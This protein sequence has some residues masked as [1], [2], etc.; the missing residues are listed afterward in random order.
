MTSTG[1][2]Q[3]CSASE[4]LRRVV[5]AAAPGSEPAEV[6]FRH[7]LAWRTRGTARSPKTTCLG[8]F[9]S[10]KEPA[11][12]ERW[13][14]SDVDFDS[15]VRRDFL[16][17]VT[18][19]V[20]RGRRRRPR[21]DRSDRGTHSLVSQRRG[22]HL[23]HDRAPQPGDRSRRRSH[24]GSV[25]SSRSV[26]IIGSRSTLPPTTP[27]RSGATRR[28]GSARW[29]SCGTMSRGPTEPGMTAC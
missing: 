23:P 20:D 12:T 29:A 15:D 4:R 26:V 18:A 10:S 25:S 22:G 19:F 16:G 1:R 28:W 27:P 5:T 8:S 13:G 14:H 9:R 3:G 6:R 7:D 2:S 17:L 11:V 21:R 24:D